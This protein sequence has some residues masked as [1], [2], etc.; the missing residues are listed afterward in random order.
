[1]VVEFL[2]IHA[3]YLY[4]YLHTYNMVNS[5]EIHYIKREQITTLYYNIFY[6]SKIYDIHI[7]LCTIHYNRYIRLSGDWCARQYASLRFDYTMLVCMP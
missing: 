5:T 6:V 3:I 4:L 7:L 1:M 2:T